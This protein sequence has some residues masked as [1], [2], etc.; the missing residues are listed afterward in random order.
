MVFISIPSLD[1][2]LIQTTPE[3]RLLQRPIET[4]KAMKRYFI[5]VDIGYTNFMFSRVKRRHV[6]FRLAR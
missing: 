4:T 5:R 2:P 6:N 1:L 3:I